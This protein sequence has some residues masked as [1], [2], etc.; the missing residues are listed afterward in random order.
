[1]AKTAV[2]D[3]EKYEVTAAAHNV[4]D[5]SITSGDQISRNST[6]EEIAAGK[7]DEQKIWS[8]C[9]V[10]GYRREVDQAT[11]KGNVEAKSSGK[12]IRG[13][14]QKTNNRAL[15]A[16]GT[17]V[18]Y[19]SPPLGPQKEAALKAQGFGHISVPK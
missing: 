2:T 17:S 15:V 4:A 8:V 19:K 18:T 10:C 13:S 1:M 16:S 5:G 7:D 11:D 12:A 3:G 14:N 6:P 9:T